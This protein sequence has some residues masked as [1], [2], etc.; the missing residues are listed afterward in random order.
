MRLCRS[1]TDYMKMGCWKM[2]PPSQV[3]EL[4]EVCLGS[5]HFSYN[6]N[7]E[8]NKGWHGLFISAVVANPY[9]EFFEELALESAPAR[10]KLGKQYMDDT[11]CIVEG[12][13]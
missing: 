4:L 13:T 1:S 10:P 11:C 5:T 12:T 3:A 9:V 8:Q 2:G 6:G 7:Y